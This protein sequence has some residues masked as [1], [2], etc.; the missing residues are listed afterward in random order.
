MIAHDRIRLIGRLHFFTFETMQKSPISIYIHWPFCKAKCPYCDFNSH[1]RESVSHDDWLAAYIKEINYFRDLL[2]DKEIVSIFFGGGTPSLAS[3]KVMEGIINELSNIADFHEDI[4][5]TLEANPTSIEAQ[6]FKEFASAGINRVSVG[7]QSLNDNDLKFLGRE[8]SAHEALKAL[9]IAKNIFKRHTFDL[10]Y[11]LPNQSLEQWNK[12][13]DTALGYAGKHLSLYQLTIEKGTRFYKD[14]RDGKF[15]MPSEDLAADMYEFTTAHMEAKGLPYYEV[16][17]YAVPAEESKHNM[18]YWKYGNYLG[19]GPGAHG[20]FEQAGVKYM[21][22]MISSPEAWMKQV[23]QTGV[24]FQQKNKLDEASVDSEK[25]IMGLRL[26][27]GVDKSL[28]KNT[29]KFGDYVR[30]GLLVEYGGKVSVTK[31]GVLLL[32]NIIAELA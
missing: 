5:I 23:N 9:E 19:I 25:L 18:C 4:E 14:H 15:V 32:N 6:K 24:G 3:P 22:Q 1:V 13:L 29:V 2:S 26:R 17:N 20:R 8:H 16:S 12:E 31:K 7:I 27:E 28:I 11:S 10:I 21:S 30:H